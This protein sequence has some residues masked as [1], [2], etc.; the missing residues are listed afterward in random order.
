VALS[1]DDSASN[2]VTS[3]SYLA[4]SARIVGIPPAGGTMTMYMS[5]EST[6]RTSSGVKGLVRSVHI[7]APNDFNGEWPITTIGLTSQTAG[8][9]GRHGQLFDIWFGSDFLHGKT[10]P[11]TLEK[12][13][14]QFHNI[15]VPWNGEG[16]CI[17]G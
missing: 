8:A 17:R 15:V 4:N 16:I 13:F 12:Q 2:P 7:P 3:H 9:V 10:Y 11:N 6:W 14:A 1:V 5:N